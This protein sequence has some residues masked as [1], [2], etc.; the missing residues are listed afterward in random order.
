M[1]WSLYALA[2]L[3]AHSP[4]AR[5]EKWRRWARAVRR[6]QRRLM[7]RLL[8]ELNGTQEI[9][10]RPPPK[11]MPWTLDDLESYRRQKAGYS[12]RYYG[13]SRSAAYEFKQGYKAYRP[14]SKGWSRKFLGFFKTEAEAGWA[15]I[16][17]LNPDAVTLS[18]PTE[19]AD[20]TN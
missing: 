18:P 12:S 9:A 3:N 1:C 17:A 20:V 14:A 4:I 13:V 2:E 15:V 19:T 7:D 16:K 6:H 8:R 5:A 10:Q 11:R